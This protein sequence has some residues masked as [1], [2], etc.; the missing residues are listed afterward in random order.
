MNNEDNYLYL[1]QIKYFANCLSL[2]TNTQIDLFLEIKI[3][4]SETGK[5]LLEQGFCLKW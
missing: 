2:C 4:K 1:Q 5:I 3:Y